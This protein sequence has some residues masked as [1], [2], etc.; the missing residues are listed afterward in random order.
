[1]T[2]IWRDRPP[3]TSTWPTPLTL[4]IRRRSTLSAYSVMSRTGRVD[5]TATLSTGDASGSIFSMAGCSAVAGRLC[6]TR[7]TLSRTSCAATSTFFS[8]RNVTM[9]CDTPSDETERSSSMPLMVLTASSILS[10]ISVSTCSGAAPG[11]RVVIDD[12]R[13]ID[14]G[15]PVD[16]QTEEGE[17][18]DDRERQNQDGRE[19]GTLDAECREPL[20]GK[21]PSTA[22]PER[23]RPG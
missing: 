19:D 21:V 4:S 10:L 1:M 7:L 18:A 3:T 14:L 9:T 20:H 8:S 12:R 16:A 11:S 6:S 17:A 22:L 13:Q 15:E 5:V 2:L 23:R